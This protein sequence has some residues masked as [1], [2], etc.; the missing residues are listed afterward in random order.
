MIQDA[1]G[2]RPI[3]VYEIRERI[4]ADYYADPANFAEYSDGIKGLIDDAAEACEIKD[5]PYRARL[6]NVAWQGAQNRPTGEQRELEFLEI[7]FELSDIILGATLRK[8]T[9]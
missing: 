3:E 8:E 7:A 5:K 1:H 6:L 2:E 4:E 9:K